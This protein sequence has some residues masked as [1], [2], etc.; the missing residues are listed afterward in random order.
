MR[1]TSL[2]EVSPLR[3]AADPGMDILDEKS[4]IPVAP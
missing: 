3:R 2:I 1:V 4:L